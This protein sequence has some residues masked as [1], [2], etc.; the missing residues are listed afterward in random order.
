MEQNKK[1]YFGNDHAVYE[2]KSEVIDYLKSLGYF[3][4]D[5]GPSSC[6]GRV[7]YPNYAVK[8]AQSVQE[9]ANSVGVLLCGTGIGMSIAA[10]KVSGIRA[11]L[12]Y[13][14]SSAN[15]AKEHNNA[16]VVCIGAREH[17]LEEIKKML[18]AYL[19]AEFSHERH[20]DRIA[21]ITEYENKAKK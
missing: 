15:L 4:E 3:V 12:V 2:I 21:L 6:D 11:A 9:D 19:A 8:V 20:E 7:D 10:N 14:V 18:K 1:I 13:N 5:E 17:S 16:N